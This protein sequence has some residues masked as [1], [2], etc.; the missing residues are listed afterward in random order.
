MKIDLFT[1]AREDRPLLA[2]ALLLIATFLLGF[3]DSLMKLM[4]SQTSFWQIQTLRSLGNIALLVLLAC[5]SGNLL[6]LHARNWRGVYLRATFLAVCMFCFFS[7]APFLSVAQMAIGL[8]TYPLFVCALA[9]PILGE[10]IGRW[11]IASILIG[12][13]G[14][15]LV[16]SPWKESF[17]A[18]QILPVIAGFFFACNI[19][20]LRSLCRHESTLALAFAAG[21]I[22]LISG[23]CGIVGLTVL[24]LSESVQSQMPYVA[25]GWPT[26]T[27]TVAGFAVLASFLNLTGNI[28]MT[29][30]YQTADVSLLAPL[31]FSYLIFAALWGKVLFDNVPPIDTLFG[32]LLIICAGIIIAWREQINNKNRIPQRSTVKV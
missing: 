19:L 16:L 15:L 6:L 2:I 26:L 27:M 29:R 7:G 11:R 13:A 25:I 5:L 1:H 12:S 14:A 4:S 10:T 9:G 31:D 18:V 17:S 3:Q 30:A 22:F 32:M 20:A 24:P 23:L 8:Y 28:C 21:L